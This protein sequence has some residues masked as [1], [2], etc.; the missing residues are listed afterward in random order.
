MPGPAGYSKEYEGGPKSR[1]Q[2][3]P[4]HPLVQQ[5]GAL[6]QQLLR[7]DNEF[8]ADIGASQNPLLV[9]FITE[10]KYYYD[11][12]PMAVGGLPPSGKSLDP[13]HE[14]ERLDPVHI[15]VGNLS[16]QVR[17]RV[18]ADLQAAKEMVFRWIAEAGDA[19]TAAGF[20]GWLNR[21][22]PDTAKNQV[23]GLVQCWKRMAPDQAALEGVQY[24][25]TLQRQRYVIEPSQD[26]LL[27]CRIPK[28]PAIPYAFERKKYDTGASAVAALG[29]AQGRAMWIQG[30]SGRF[31]SST[32][33]A[34]GKF[35]HS[36]YL[37]GR[38]IKAGGEWK[39]TDGKLVVIAAK[40]GHYRP[41]LA[42]L[43]GA[44]RDLYGTS[45]ASG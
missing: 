11:K 3:A 22:A 45:P 28:N 19:G 23:T 29:G 25:T 39:V 5:D 42:M 37:G 33:Q 21:H 24:L 14:F 13:A 35:H 17:A 6:N 32:N 2:S 10:L 15:F 16:P 9:R 18:L 36:S 7:E 44:V 1:P 38:A 41:S 8:Q 43:K 12:G 30:P 34:V 27:Y 40:S 4:P 26:G 20:V 31:Y